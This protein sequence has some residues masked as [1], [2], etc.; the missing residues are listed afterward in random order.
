MFII[1]RTCKHS[2]F[3]RNVRSGI[4]T[5]NS[6]LDDAYLLSYRGKRSIDYPA[7]SKPYNILPPL[8]RRDI[9][10]V[11]VDGSPCTVVRPY[12]NFDPNPGNPG[13]H[14]HNRRTR[15]HFLQEMFEV[16]LELVS[17]TMPNVM[18]LPTELP[19]EKIDRL[20]SPE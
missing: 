8:E 15:K 9:W 10:D 3:K 4:R 6:V 7:Q 13:R 18:V 19:G 2:F 14:V 20:P 1:R 12:L 17:S 5:T 16:G 11:S